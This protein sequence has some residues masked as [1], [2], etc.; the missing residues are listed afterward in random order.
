MTAVTVNGREGEAFGPP[1]VRVID[2]VNRILYSLN[3]GM[4][5]HSDPGRAISVSRES[6]AAEFSSM[7]R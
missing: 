3:N 4:G 5:L 1:E 6:I 2:V 7:I